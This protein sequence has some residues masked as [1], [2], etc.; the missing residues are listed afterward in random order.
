M[1]PKYPGDRR[2]LINRLY[3]TMLPGVNTYNCFVY[4]GHLPAPPLPEYVNPFW[5][6]GYLYKTKVPETHKQWFSKNA[7]DFCYTQSTRPHLDRSVRKMDAPVCYKFEDDPLFPRVLEFLSNKWSQPLEVGSMSPG[8]ILD[9]M[10]LDKAPGYLETW[11]GFRKKSDCLRSGLLSEYQDLQMLEEIPLWKVSGKNELK[12]T[13]KY[14]GELK[15][16]TFIIEPLS[17]LWHDKRI[18]G[19]QNE[20]IKGYWW[21]AYGFNPYDGGVTSMATVL[22]QFQRFWEF[23]VVGFDR[24]NPLMRYVQDLRLA[25]VRPDPFGPWVVKHKVKSRLVLP[26]GDVIEKS[27]GNNSG[28][29]T[30]TGDNILTMSFPLVHTFMELGLDENAIHQLVWAFIFGDDVLGGDNINVT[31]EVFREV[32]IRVFS[33]YGFELDPFVITHDIEGM[34]FLGFNIHQIQPGQ[35]VPKYKLPRLAYSFQHSEF[36]FL[37]VD[38]ELTKM[39]SLM[40][41]S[42]GHGEEVYNQFRDSVRYVVANTSHPAT[43]RILKQGLDSIPTFSDTIDWYLG[44]LEGSSHITDLFWRMVGIKEILCENGESNESTSAFGKSSEG[45]GVPT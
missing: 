6:D 5:G 18:F 32:L 10:D 34:S 15:Q 3:Q 45:S 36:D 39:L 35:F 12:E 29:G 31:D 40:L 27:W 23:D 11:R 14:I 1:G 9:S 26:N 41:M 25:G 20:A 17:M 22:K 8:E 30:T 21:S 42:A 19:N 7:G 16:R 2:Q 43:S 28:S 38:K 13:E 33:L 24:L 44:R 4:L 37:D